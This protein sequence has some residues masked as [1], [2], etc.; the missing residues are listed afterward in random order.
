[1]EQQQTTLDKLTLDE[2]QQ[3]LEQRRDDLRT[4]CKELQDVLQI[5]DNPL[6]Y[7]ADDPEE[8]LTEVVDGANIIDYENDKFSEFTM[9]VLDE[10]GLWRGKEFEQER[11]VKEER[12][13]KPLTAITDAKNKRDLEKVVVKYQVFDELRGKTDQ[14]KGAVE[15]KQAMLDVYDKNIAKIDRQLNKKTKWAQKN[16]YEKKQRPPSGQKIIAGMFVEVIR[17]G[18]PLTQREI[19]NKIAQRYTKVNPHNIYRYVNL[20]V[21]LGE[22]FNMLK[23]GEDMKV[24]KTDKQ[25]IRL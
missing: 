5:T 22:Q 23:R 25:S 20:F 6:R 12:K 3:F 7:N 4:T 17:E 18:V 21:E 1:M 14:Y 10:L 19:V 13:K 8:L 11:K 24:R 15:L 2:R 16:T 9:R